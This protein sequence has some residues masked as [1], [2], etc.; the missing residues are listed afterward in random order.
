MKYCLEVDL[1]CTVYAFIICAVINSSMDRYAIMSILVGGSLANIRHIGYYCY[2]EGYNCPFP[3]TF[4]IS[5]CGC[6]QMEYDKKL[7]IFCSS[8][9]YRVLWMIGG[10]D[11]WSLVV[12]AS[13]LGGFRHWLLR[14]LNDSH[15]KG[16]CCHFLGRGLGRGI[17]RG[18]GGV[19]SHELRRVHKRN[20]GRCLGWGRRR[21]PWRG[22]L[23]VL[24]KASYTWWGCLFPEGDSSC[25]FSI[26]WQM[27]NLTGSPLYLLFVAFK[28][29]QLF[30]HINLYIKCLGRSKG[31]LSKILNS[32]VFLAGTSVHC[33]PTAQPWTSNKNKLSL[34]V[35]EKSQIIQN[36]WVNRW[37]QQITLWIILRACW[38][39]GQVIE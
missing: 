33:R 15:V 28:N 8:S 39:I 16:F 13:E 11:E 29:R 31:H 32:A 35:K 23:L 18:F 25:A 24:S 14:R 36:G 30:Y 17:G 19:R 7:M 38:L 20:C 26:K 12:F 21:W 6:F 4:D 9:W 3:S 1:G 27:I 2:L 5:Y 37:C 22:R 10:R 34:F